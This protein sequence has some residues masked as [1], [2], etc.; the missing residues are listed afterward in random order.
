MLRLS[1]APASCPSPASDGVAHPFS[2]RRWRSSRGCLKR[3]SPASTAAVSGSVNCR[4]GS[5]V[6]A[7][8][9][10]HQAGRGGGTSGCM[11]WATPRCSTSQGELLRAP[12]ENFVLKISGPQ[13]TVGVRPPPPQHPQ[14]FWDFSNSFF[15]A[16]NTK[17]LQYAFFKTC[18]MLKSKGEKQ[19]FCLP[20][21]VAAGLG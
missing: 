12:K 8:P 19:L 7:S 13:N 16:E 1:C 14:N 20:S 5:C 15:R 9:S 18:N 2:R 4:S 11:G 17:A 6:G 10:R 3:A 21:W